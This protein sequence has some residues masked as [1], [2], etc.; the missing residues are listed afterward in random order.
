MIILILCFE[1]F[2]RQ[3]MNIKCLIF[4][5]LK[6]LLIRGVRARIDNFKRLDNLR[7]KNLVLKTIFDEYT[8]IPYELI[9]QILELLKSA[10]CA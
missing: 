3:T 5:H 1:R 9:H 2:K 4:I 8:G 7:K 10:S 6:L